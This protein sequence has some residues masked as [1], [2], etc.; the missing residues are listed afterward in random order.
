MAFVMVPVQEA[1]GGENTS[2]RASLV[3]GDPPQQIISVLVLLRYGRSRIRGS[4]FLG[5]VHPPPQKTT[6]AFG[7]AI[8]PT[9]YRSGIHRRTLPGDKRVSGIIPVGRHVER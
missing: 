1:E 3:R 9:G 7:Y 4:V 2:W 5:D 6:P 8:L